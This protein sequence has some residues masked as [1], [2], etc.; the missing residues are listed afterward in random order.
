MCVQLLPMLLETSSHEPEQCGDDDGG[1]SSVGG[2]SVL[3]CGQWRARLALAKS[4]GSMAN[5]VDPT[6][7]E[8][9]IMPC[10]VRLTRDPVWAVRDEARQQLAGIEGG[11]AAE[12]CTATAP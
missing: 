12:G 1:G 7:V 8:K 9:H 6:L 10:A 2:K 11:R 5:R 4:L 3:R